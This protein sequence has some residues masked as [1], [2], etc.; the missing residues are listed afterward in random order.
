MAA[1]CVMP[2]YLAKFTFVDLLHLNTSPTSS[3]TFA[4]WITGVIEAIAIVVV[5]L[6]SLW[7]GEKLY[8]AIAN[9]LQKIIH[10]LTKDK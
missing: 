3:D 1:I 5:L 9:A 4:V 7:I 2:Y 8:N 6:G 10:P